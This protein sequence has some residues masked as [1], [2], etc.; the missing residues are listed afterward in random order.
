MG[1]AFPLALQYPEPSSYPSGP[2]PRE[3][4][5]RYR[6][7]Q[8]DQPPTPVQ[9]SNRRGGRKPT[10][11]RAHAREKYPRE[12]RVKGE[13]PAHAY[14]LEYG[15]L[16]IVVFIIILHLYLRVACKSLEAQGRYYCCCCCRCFSRRLFRQALFLVSLVCLFSTYEVTRTIKSSGRFRDTSRR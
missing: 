11:R 10:G 7:S 12:V 16:G 4:H 5:H 3:G 13:S 6:R 2:K 14:S 1:W 8:N 15:L 9:S